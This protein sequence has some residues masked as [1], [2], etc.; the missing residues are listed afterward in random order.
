MEAISKPL[1]ISKHFQL[2]KLADG[3]YAAI[4]VDG[5]G[6]MSNAGIID[7]GDRIVIFDTFFTPQ[8]AEDLRIAIEQ[9]TDKP[10]TYVINSHMHGDHVHGNQVFAPQADII[11]TPRTRALIGTRVVENL[12]ENTSDIAGGQAFVKSLEEQVEQEKNEDKRRQLE[13]S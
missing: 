9:L 12:A 4:S 8:A 7:L 5:T 10:V 13:L 1:P 3:V 11:A 2:E 6:S